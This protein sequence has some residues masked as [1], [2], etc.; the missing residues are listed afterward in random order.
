MDPVSEFNEAGPPQHGDGRDIR[1]AEFRP[2][3]NN[4]FE[5]AIEDICN[6]Q[7][8]AI[9]LRQA[10]PADAADAA[11]H[12]INHD[13]KLPWL[14]P[15]STGPS[16]DIRVLGVAATRSFDTPGGPSVDNYFDNVDRYESVTEGLF[17]T[18][19]GVS[20]YL[21]QLLGRAAGK[22]PVERLVNVDRRS[23]AA[24]TVRSLHEGQ[25]IVLHNDHGHVD[26]PVY[27]D[28]ISSL[29][30]SMTL[31]FFALLQ[32]PESGGRLIVYGVTHSDPVPRLANGYP[33]SAAIQSRY[34]FE[35]FELCARDA[36]IFGAGKFYHR[37]EPV[38]GPRPRVT[39]GG[40][41]AFSR[42][43]QK[44]FYWN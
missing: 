29:D 35:A 8:D 28:V 3:A 4:N 42:N 33:D 39:L 5:N 43:R 32:A 20:R 18:D 11:L 41:L 22:R 1:W 30:T 24:C 7:L 16:A 12:T 26:L 23:F 15:N 13:T 21:E 14:R 36:I 37:V 38:E 40:F 25:G 31:S 2:G 6:D 9:V 19:F 17:G 44:V 10:F 27:A 34:K